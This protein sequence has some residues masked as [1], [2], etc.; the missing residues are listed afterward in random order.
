MKRVRFY[1]RFFE[2]YTERA[3]A[4][5]D[6][7][8]LRREYTYEGYY[9][10]QELTQARRIALRLGYVLL[11]ALELYFFWRG[12][13][14][15]SV[16]N[17]HPV[18]AVC[19]GLHLLCDIWL[20]WILLFYVTAPRDMTVYQYKSTALQLAKAQKFSAAVNLALLAAAAAVT[21]TAGGG[22]IDGL[23][24]GA[25]EYAAAALLSVI[26]LLTERGL[27]YKKLPNN[28]KGAGQEGNHL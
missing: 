5:G 1:E 11:F 21:A 4:A 8:R 15:P 10:R 13:C 23:F 28:R 17:A 26:W 27:N 25:G 19:Q 9:Y 22:R 20:A 18:T 3:V 2:D 7:K 24:D 16:C 14:K 6:G 12:G